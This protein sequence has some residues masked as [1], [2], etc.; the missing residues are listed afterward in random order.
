MKSSIQQFLLRIR[1]EGRRKASHV[2]VGTMGRT[3]TFF[4]Y[5]WGGDTFIFEKDIWKSLPDHQPIL[6][7]RKQDLLRG[8]SGYVMT[9]STGNH[10][11]AAI[12]LLSGRF[13]NIGR[14]AASQQSKLLSTHIVCA[15]IMPGSIE[16]SQRDVPTELVVEAD[17]WLQGLGLRLDEIVMAERNDRTL[18][19]YRRQGQE[20]RV[21]PLAW[22]PKE[23][24]FAIRSSR[25]RINSSL[26]YYHSAKGVHF[27]TYQDFHLL[28]ELARQ[29]L[30]KFTECLRELVSI[31]E[32]GT[33]S[34]LRMP[35][36]HGHHEIELFGL[37]RGEAFKFIIP[38]LEKLMEGIVLS[39]L[40]QADVIDRIDA[41]D[42]VFKSSLE[43]PALADETS[44]DFRETLY[45]H[46]TGLIYIG[47]SDSLAPAFDDRR[48]PLPGATFRGGRPE[49]H[50]G[51][52]ERT[53][54]LLANVMQTMSEEEFLEYAN[55]YELRTHDEL[56]LGQ[57]VTREIVYKTNRRPLGTSLIEKQLKLASAGYG[58]YVLARV[59]AFKSLGVGFGE[60]HLLSQREESHGRLRDHFIRNRC[61][62][63]KLAAIPER[64]F[65]RES[66]Y[67]DPLPG[68]DPAVVLALA[69]LIGNAAAQNLALKK[70][71]PEENSCRFGEG[72]EIYE[73][74]YDLEARREMPQRVTICSVRGSL[75]WPDLSYSEENLDKLFDFYISRYAEVLVGFWK[76]HSAAVA[77]PLVASRFFDGFELKTRSMQWAYSLRREQYDEFDPKLP[78]SFRF[79]RKWKFALWALERQ[80]RRIEALRALFLAKVKALAP[81]PPAKVQPP[82]T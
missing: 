5:D 16:L 49:Y 75:G 10:A 44:Q 66:E 65:C 53:R 34:F 29:D 20:W 51:I 25:N 32:G 35:K 38:E 7:I 63:E 42:K 60:Y 80:M 33:S 55:I 19:Y 11:V 13:W 56:P 36:F 2:V 48:T 21:K 77:L 73:F 58:S 22:T 50:P 24:E 71:L 47:Q 46:L 69:G 12:P 67:G 74:G 30:G 8:S 31:F 4:G 37:C 3:R 78:P 54:I 26:H 9:L 23:I 79:N 39:R 40:K 27:L 43:R 1:H 68:E 52:D 82:S 81:Q 57:G 18:E 45:L 72:K 59:Y 70:Y 28:T 41:I 61:L 15:N 17:E 6:L 62:G 64:I 14:V 76:A